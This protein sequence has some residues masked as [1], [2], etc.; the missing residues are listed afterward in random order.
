MS[1]TSTSTFNFK[2]FPGVILVTRGRGRERRKEGEEGADSGLVCYLSRTGLRLEWNDTLSG[3]R[4][5]GT[6]TGVMKMQEWKMQE[7]KNRER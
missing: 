5:G 4:I 3:Q 1:P 7:W 6:V 2:N